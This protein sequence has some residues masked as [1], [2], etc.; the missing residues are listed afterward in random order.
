MGSGGEPWLDSHSHVIGEEKL[1]RQGFATSSIYTRFLEVCPEREVPL[2]GGSSSSAPSR[3]GERLWQK[4]FHFRHSSQRGI[5][6]PSY[7]F[8]QAQNSIVV[9]RSC[10]SSSLHF[11]IHFF[12]KVELK[13]PDLEGDKEDEKDKVVAVELKSHVRVFG[14]ADWPG[15]TVVWPLLSRRLGKI[16]IA[17]PLPCLLTKT[18]DTTSWKISLWK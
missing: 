14:G 7:R 17:S 10:L 2:L 6:K 1:W 4:C 15:V 18:L 5:S 13:N 3:E 8:I 11:E 9:G 16:P 12:F